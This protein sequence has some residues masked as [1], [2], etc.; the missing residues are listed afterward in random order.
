MK[1]SEVDRWGDWSSRGI[2]LRAARD[3]FIHQKKKKGKKGKQLQP[4]GRRVR[5][6]TSRGSCQVSI[7]SDVF[8]LSHF[9]NCQ[10]RNKKG[11]KEKEK[12][13][14]LPFFSFQGS[15]C[16][17][18]IFDTYLSCRLIQNYSWMAHTHLPIQVYDILKPFL[19]H[20]VLCVD[21]SFPGR[22]PTSFLFL[23]TKGNVL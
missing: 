2:V 11:R 15:L 14:I 1:K 20:F 21:P 19:R 17:I 16:C 4:A 13:K 22:L 6:G 5:L 18:I 9:C 12:K 7:R 10:S 23:Y 3:L 8:F